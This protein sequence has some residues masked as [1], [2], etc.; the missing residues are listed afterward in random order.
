MK[1]DIYSPEKIRE[2]LTGAVIGAFADMA[3]LDAAETGP[4]DVAFGPVLSMGL[5]LTEPVFGELLMY[6]SLDCKKKILE[7]MFDRDIEDLSARDIDDCLLEML[8][9]IGGNLMGCLSDTGK[10]KLGFP[11]VLFTDEVSETPA[12]RVD[13]CFDAEG[14]PFKVSVTLR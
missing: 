8:N 4:V 14:T 10:F 13:V 9:V 11:E 5:S 7:N 3:F 2:A 12:E 1:K 6:L